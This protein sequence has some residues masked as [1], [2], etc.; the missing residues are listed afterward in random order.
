MTSPREQLGRRARR[1]VGAALGVAV[2]GTTQVAG[3]GTTGLNGDTPDEATSFQIGSVTKV[4][5]A[6]LLADAVT[7]GELAAALGVHH[8]TIGYR[9]RGEYSPSLRLTLPIAA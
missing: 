9:E 3:V 2:D 4:V 1:H 7:R 5:T 8:Q 6:L